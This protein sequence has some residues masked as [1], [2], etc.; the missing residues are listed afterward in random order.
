MP[1]RTTT[2]TPARASYE[3]PGDVVSDV[4]RNFTGTAHARERLV[5][6]LS[7]AAEAYDRHRYEEALRLARNVSDAVPSVAPVRELAGLSAYRA[8]RW[9][10]ARAHLRAHFELTEDPEHLP[11][12]MDCER[13]LRRYRGVERVF[14]EVAAHDPTPD[15]LAEARIVMAG[16]W[17]DQGKFPEALEL[18]QRAGGS[19]VLRNPAFRH[20][21][22]WYALGDVL[23]R[24]GD[25]AGAREMFTRVVRADPE[26]YDAADR[27]AEL[28]SPSPRKNRPRRSAPTSTKRRV[29]GS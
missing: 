9:A 10:M 28:G 16:A 13:A 17:A 2:P 19:R 15:V 12:I 1:A 14:E 4:R 7:K 6:T 29:E 24:A 23:D 11:L 18:L 3:L 5:V 21:R 22:L 27:L 8:G 20:V 26:A 25:T